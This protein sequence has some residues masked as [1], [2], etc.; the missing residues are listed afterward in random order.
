MIKNLEMNLFS[1]R[2]ADGNIN[3]TYGISGEHPLSPMLF[4]KH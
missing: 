4:F 2:S 1:D 3:L